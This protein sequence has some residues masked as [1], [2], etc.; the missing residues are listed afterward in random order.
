VTTRAEPVMTR[1]HDAATP[2][3]RG[4]EAAPGIQEATQEQR[5]LDSGYCPSGQSR[6]GAPCL[7]KSRITT[8]RRLLAAGA[9]LPLF[10]IISRRGAAAR[11]K[12]RFK[13]AGNLPATHP[14]NV[15]VKEILP[16]ILEESGGQLEVRMFPNNQLGGDS[17]MLSQLR[18]GALEMFLCSGTNVLSTMAKQTALYGVG[19]AFKDY[20]QV[21]SALDGG[22]GAY[23]RGIIAKVNLHAFDKLWDIGFRQIT[24]S[25]KPILVPD[26]L[27]GF[28]IRVPVSPLW[29]SLFQHLG[30]APTSI[31]FSEVYSA[32]QTHIVDGQENPLSLILIAKLYE[33]QKHISITNHMW[34]GQF[35]LVNG[36]VWRSL[37]E[38]LQEVLVRNFASATLKEREDLVQLNKSAEGELTGLGLQFHRTDPEAFRSA[39][40]KAGYYKKW[41]ATFGDEAWAMLEK[42]SGAL[43]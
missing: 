6:N 14:I 10:S 34:D 1:D 5:I 29:G 20:S 25:S 35:T 12:Y 42:Y 19:F 2:S 43:V 37:P 38:N 8:R 9:A 40:A 31:N 4:R 17:D 30:A 3:F 16:K 26:D 36:K 28:K 39:V 23:L 27:K 24:S 7:D 15:R 32:L 18:S 13:F 22:L 11:P 41:R 21:W 33:V